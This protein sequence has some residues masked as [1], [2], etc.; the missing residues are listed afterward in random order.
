M[1]CIIAAMAPK[2]APE[3]TA[4]AEENSEDWF[5][6][7]K[8]SPEDQADYLAAIEEGR[9]DFAAGRTVSAEKVRL[10][11]ESL[12]TDHELPPPECE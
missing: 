12:G 5:D 7:E 8:L 2:T 10:W 4:E 9:A 11:I 6:L 1:R 3:S